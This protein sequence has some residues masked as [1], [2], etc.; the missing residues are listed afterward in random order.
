MTYQHLC[1][2]LLQSSEEELVKRKSLLLIPEVIGI[3]SRP[4]D[5]SPTVHQFVSL[6]QVE[7]FGKVHLLSSISSSEYSADQWES[8]MN[9]VT[10][11]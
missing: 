6:P 7:R 3:S 9:H 10:P 4:G 1:Q 11:A 8:P 5:I 2:V